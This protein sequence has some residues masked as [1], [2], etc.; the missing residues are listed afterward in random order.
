MFRAQST[1]FPRSLENYWRARAMDKALTVFL[2]ELFAR[3]S[4]STF[5]DLALSALVSVLARRD[6]ASLSSVPSRPCA[7]E[8]LAAWAV[9]LKAVSAFFRPYRCFFNE[10]RACPTSS[11]DPDPMADRDHGGHW[12]RLR[13]L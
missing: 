1:Q 5:G 3:S 11:A 4:G 7:S 8:L 13:Y 2:C 10:R 6:W 9:W 12:V